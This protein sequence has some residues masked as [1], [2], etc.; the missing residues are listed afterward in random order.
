M[1][2]ITDL[3]SP[4]TA[5]I[6]RFVPDATKKAELAQEL[7]TLAEKQAHEIALAQ[8]DLNKAEAQ[9]GNLFASGWRPYI[10]WTCGF[11]LSYQFVLRQ[12]I[13]DAV[14]ISGHATPQLTSLDMSDLMPILLGLLGL[15]TMR[16][17]EYVKGVMK[18]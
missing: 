15:G 3:I 18:K 8:I 4:I 6:D 2:V 17:V 5:I 16:T 10:G 9:S 1:S 11:A 13:V 7:A 14:V 12:M